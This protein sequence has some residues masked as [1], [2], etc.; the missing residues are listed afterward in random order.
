MSLTRIFMQ[1][2]CVVVLFI[3]AILFAQFNREV[4]KN[5]PTSISCDSGVSLRIRVFFYHNK[6]PKANHTTLHGGPTLYTGDFT[7]YMA[8]CPSM[9]FQKWFYFYGNTLLVQ[10]EKTLPPWKAS[11]DFKNTT[12]DM[13]IAEFKDT[14][15]GRFLYLKKEGGFPI[16][17]VD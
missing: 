10:A 16:G 11:G 1:S 14:Q 12:P 8:L 4:L 15:T 5:A 17:E 6:M 7:S 13:I 3:P 9:V 2:F